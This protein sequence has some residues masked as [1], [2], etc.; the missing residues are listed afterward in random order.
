MLQ[1]LQALQTMQSAASD[2]S[3]RKRCSP[4]FVVG[5]LGPH[6]PCRS[7]TRVLILETVPSASVRGQSRTS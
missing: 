6:E 7:P 5:P 3:G 4:C 2:A 1:P